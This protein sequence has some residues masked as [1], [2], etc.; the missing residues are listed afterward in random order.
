MH[1][2]EGLRGGSHRRPRILKYVL[3]ALL[4]AAIAE[5][6]AMYLN[7]SREKENRRAAVELTI[8]AAAPMDG[9][10]PAAAR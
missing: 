5:P 8:E 3:V 1:S 2:T 9:G 7:L 4:L 10:S 6:I